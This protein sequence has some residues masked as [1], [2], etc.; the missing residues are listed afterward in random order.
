MDSSYGVAG[1]PERLRRRDELYWDLS[2]E[3]FQ[4]FGAVFH[5]RLLRHHMAQHD[6]GFLLTRRDRVLR[7]LDEFPFVCL[8]DHQH[9]Y[10][11][12]REKRDA[13]RQAHVPPTRKHAFDWQLWIACYAHGA[14]LQL[15][16]HLFGEARERRPRK[17]EHPRILWVGVL[18]PA[19]FLNHPRGDTVRAP[20]VPMV[21]EM[22]HNH[23]V[24]IKD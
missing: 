12:A 3:P 20:S 7:V 9:I 11:G 24:T 6:E 4:P 8:P 13:R 14:N 5:P 10:V 1:R 22:K 19:Q 2:D 21:V 23:I 15:R 17:R 16:F 18:L